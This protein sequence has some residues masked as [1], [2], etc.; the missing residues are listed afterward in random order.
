[1]SAAASIEQREL[2]DV[3]LRP[4]LE[5]IDLLDWRAFDRAIDIGYRDAVQALEHHAA[6]LM[7]TT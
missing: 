3:V 2:A 4:P 5:R 6:R 1:M 7:L